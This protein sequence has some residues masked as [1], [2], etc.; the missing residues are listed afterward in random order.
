[1][2]D[3]CSIIYS[4]SII[5][6]SRILIDDS[7][8]MLQ[9]VASFTIAIYDHH[10]LYNSGHSSCLVTIKMGKLVFTPQIKNLVLLQITKGKHSSLFSHAV[11]LS[12]TISIT[13]ITMVCTVN[14]FCSSCVMP[15]L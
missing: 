6:D 5:D 3:A 1:M 15:V 8:V 2:R 12:L 13:K 4:K 7:R 10:V 9:L 11:M 14:I